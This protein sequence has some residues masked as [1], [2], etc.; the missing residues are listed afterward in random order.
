MPE[1]G[2]EPGSAAAPRAQVTPDEAP[3]LPRDRRTVAAAGDEQAPPDTVS[4]RH[5]A[6]W[7]ASVLVLAVALGALRELES[8][9]LLRQCLAAVLAVALAVG[10]AVRAG[11]RA[12]PAGVLAAVIAVA[13]V[14]TRWPP[15]LAGAAIGTA[16]LAACLAV[17]GTRPAARLRAVVPEVVLAQLVALVG[18]VGAAGF[19]PEADRERFGYTVLALAMVATVAL[20]HRLGGGLHGLGRRG[21]VLFVM[22]LA[23]LGVVLV[24]AAALTQYG[25]PELVDR[26]RTAQDWTREHLGGVPRPVEVLVGVPALAWGVTMRH[27]RRQGWWVSVFGVTATAATAS[28]LVDPGAELGTVA[29]SAAYCVVLGLLVGALVIRLEHVIIGRERRRARSTADDEQRHEPD[30]LQALH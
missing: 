3:A 9:T 6:A 17:L 14:A 8:P 2:N 4:Q 26:V 16:V 25:S 18:A 11:G 24:Y 23:L 13:A 29:L 20:V 27:R 22:E 1:V 28:R 5:A 7:V 19:A 10:L 21:L 15:L 30:R 12:L